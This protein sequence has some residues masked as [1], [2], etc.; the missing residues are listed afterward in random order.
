MERKEVKAWVIRH[1]E[2]EAN[3]AFSEA[4]PTHKNLPDEVRFRADLVDSK[5]TPKGHT[6]ARE[7][8]S[9]LD[10]KTSRLKVIFVSPM[11]RALQ[12]TRNILNSME[13]KTVTKVYVLPMFREVLESCC[14]V[15]SD[16]RALRKE[17]SLYDWSAFDQVL[18][19]K[20]KSLTYWLMTLGTAPGS[21]GIE[22]VH[23]RLLKRKFRTHEDA[24]RD[25][26]AEFLRSMADMMPT[27]CESREQLWRRVQIA[28]KFAKDFIAKEGLKDGELAI[29]AHGIFLGYFLANPKELDRD[30]QLINK[31]MLKN[32]CLIPCPLK[33]E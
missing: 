8:G 12:T 18:D 1:G 2:T 27:F 11:R 3:K 30:Y 29:V 22:D 28:K 14:D 21:K 23:K 15:P 9:Q 7:V 24:V 6:Q 5:L 13:H 33:L 17:F 4:D 31:P 32:C 10:S 20:D 26:E 16:I 25:M 19:N